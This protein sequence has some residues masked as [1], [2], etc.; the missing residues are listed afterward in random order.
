MTAKSPHMLAA[1]WL[2]SAVLSAQSDIAGKWTSEEQ[3]RGETVVVLQLSVKG[4]AVT[5]AVTI[6]ESP[7]QA[8]ADGKVDG[9]RLTFKTTTLLNGKEVAVLWE[10]EAHDKKLTLVRSVGTS[11]R[12]LPPIVLQRSK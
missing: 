8:L 6:G 1:I 9:N 12:K 10:G 5:G 2:I 4:A 11:G 3:S 7:A